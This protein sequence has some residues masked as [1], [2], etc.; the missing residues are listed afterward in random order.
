MKLQELHSHA[1]KDR[2][3]SPTSPEPNQTVLATKTPQP[4]PRWFMDILDIEGNCAL[5]FARE[6]EVSQ[7]LPIPRLSDLTKCNARK[8]P[9]RQA[10]WYLPRA[11]AD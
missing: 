8:N 9:V 3:I 10:S 11:A 5:G 4:L 2:L 7:S 6:S 1:Y